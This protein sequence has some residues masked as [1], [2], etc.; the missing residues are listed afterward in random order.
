MDSPVRAVPLDASQG[1]DAVATRI[2]YRQ[3]E[4]LGAGATVDVPRIVWGAVERALDGAGEVQW[5]HSVEGGPH[6]EYI[7]RFEDAL[8]LLRLYGSRE[9]VHDV[10]IEALPNP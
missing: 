9:T 6:V 1:L 2:A 7:L 5:I 3:W 4:A 10:E 8:L